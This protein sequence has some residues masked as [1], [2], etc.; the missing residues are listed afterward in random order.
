MPGGQL[1]DDADLTCVKALDVQLQ[2]VGQ[3]LPALNIYR[4]VT[5]LFPWPR[6]YPFTTAEASPWFY[7]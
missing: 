2:D 3:W 1:A 6:V 7:H 4:F 5:S